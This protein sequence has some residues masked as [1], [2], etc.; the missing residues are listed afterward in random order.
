MSGVRTAVCNSVYANI[1][2]A[3]MDV[4]LRALKQITIEYD[5]IITIGHVYGMLFRWNVCNNMSCLFNLM[6]LTFAHCIQ[7]TVYDVKHVHNSFVITHNVSSD[8]SPITV[9]RTNV[10]L[11]GVQPGETY[12]VEITPY[13]LRTCFLPHSALSLTIA[14]KGTVLVNC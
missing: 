3:S 4:V 12:T 14:I 2:L 6:S 1:I 7:Y 5:T 9:N 8:Q 11:Y 10:T 13:H